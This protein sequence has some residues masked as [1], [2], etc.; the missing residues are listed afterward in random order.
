MI[1]VSTGNGQKAQ[2]DEAQVR[3]L[4]QQGALQEDM[5]FW[6][7]G[8]A[9]WEPLRN[10]DTVPGTAVPTTHSTPLVEV[11]PSPRIHF[12]VKDPLKLTW[13][14]KMMLW[15]LFGTAVIG[16]ASDFGQ[17][18][19]AMS[20]DITS[21]AAEANDN[22]QLGIFFLHACVFI[23][24]GV[25]FLCWIYRANLNCHGFG[26]QGMKFTPGW[27]VGYYFIPIASFFMPYRSMREIWQVSTQPSHWKPVPGAGIL[28]WWWG[29]W[30]VHSVASR[31]SSKVSESVDS[32]Q[33]LKIASQVSIVASLL[34]MAS[35]LVALRLV[36][37]II[38]KQVKLTQSGEP[39]S[40]V[41]KQLA[42]I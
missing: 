41:T 4:L 42:G 36:S 25:I 34:E 24:T 15:V 6:R 40:A 31:I 32:V 22:R 14:L 11:E 10:L 7:P 13:T 30:I 33:S 29:L 21:E 35:I 19:L 9:A 2:Y 26:A 28:D 3:A 17:L 20:G 38:E 18:A 8:M 37:L 1:H 27:S 16:L 12:F 39:P 23:T 5:L